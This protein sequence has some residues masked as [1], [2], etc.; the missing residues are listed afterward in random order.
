MHALFDHE[1]NDSTTVEPIYQMHRLRRLHSAQE[2]SLCVKEED[3]SATFHEA[4]DLIQTNMR[5]GS[6]RVDVE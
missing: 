6:A 5:G 1:K 2:A 4:P 3:V